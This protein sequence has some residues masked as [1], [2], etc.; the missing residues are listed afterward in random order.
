VEKLGWRSVAEMLQGL[1][2]EEY[3]HWCIYY[4]RKA[5]HMEMAAAKAKGGD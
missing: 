1:S 2:A 5:Q 4:G 3:L